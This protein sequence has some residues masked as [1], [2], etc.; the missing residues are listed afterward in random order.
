[1]NQGI[2]W[3]GS[4]PPSTGMGIEVRV[5]VHPS[6][7]GLVHQRLANI[8]VALTIDWSE[9]LERGPNQSDR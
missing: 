3:I 4:T 7:I 8:L 2:A 9:I 1:M 6:I 5:H